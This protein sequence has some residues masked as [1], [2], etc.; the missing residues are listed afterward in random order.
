MS[1]S[2]EKKGVLHR[3]IS[4]LFRIT[5]MFILAVLIF[6]DKIPTTEFH[7][8]T[9]VQTN[10]VLLA[11]GVMALLV[12]RQLLIKKRYIPLSVFPG[13][14]IVLFVTTVLSIFGMFETGWDAGEV[15]DDAMKVATGGTI[16]PD[17]YSIYPNNRLIFLTLTFLFKPFARL[18]LDD[19]KAFYG[20][21]V[22]FQCLLFWLTGLMLHDILRIRFGKRTAM[23]GYI[24]FCLFVGINPWMFIVY[25]DGMGIIFPVLILWIFAKI[26]DA[27]WYF[28]LLKWL[29]MAFAAIAGYHMKATP[30]VM[31]IALI[32][33]A[34]IAYLGDLTEKKNRAALL[35][36]LLAGVLTVPGISISDKYLGNAF[37]TVT[38]TTI[39]HE[40]EYSS[41]DFL[42]MGLNDESHGTMNAED[43]NYSLSFGTYDERVEG[44]KDRIKERLKSYGADGLAWLYT[45]KLLLNYNDGSF[46]YGLGGEGFIG[47][48]FS[49]DSVFNHWLR[50]LIWPDRSGFNVLLNY[51]QILWLGIL[52]AMLLWQIRD[53]YSC[54]LALS[55]MGITAFTCIFEAQ[56]R[57]LLV[58]APIYVLIAAGALFKNKED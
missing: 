40:K 8:R 41:Y 28:T 51:F 1:Y 52:A 22:V 53:I 15:M 43:D 31:L 45:R 39:D 38:G 20:I 13:A 23:F 42:N 18:G 29:L 21:A 49:D 44:N 6:A 33:A 54:A 17:Y 55:I 3:L 2:Y 19:P 26:P 14:I 34:V 12:I 58:F 37:E 46:G 7:K 48:S 24:L 11:M 30:V 36:V 5:L 16:S 10:L 35:I 47:R 4:V 25:T 9:F 57:Y 27:A 32:I 50:Q 56:Q